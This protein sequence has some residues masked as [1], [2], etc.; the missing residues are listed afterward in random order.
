VLDGT[1]IQSTIVGGP[2][3]VASYLEKGDIILKI[4]GKPATKENIDTLLDSS[5]T[6]G[7]T[8]I[9]TVAKGGCE[10]CYASIR[11]S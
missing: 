2:A 6:P 4:D 9:L 7:S 1:I 3:F 10:V 8:V 5:Q 11:P